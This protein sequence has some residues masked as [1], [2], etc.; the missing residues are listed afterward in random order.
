MAYIPQTKWNVETECEDGRSE[1]RKL[2]NVFTVERN[3]KGKK[4]R[5]FSEWDRKDG[6]TQNKQ[7]LSNNK[8][9][10]IIFDFT[11]RTPIKTKRQ[12]KKYYWTPNDFTQISA[13]WENWLWFWL[14]TLL[15]LF[16]SSSSYFVDDV[17]VDTRTR[18]MRTKCTQNRNRRATEHS[19]SRVY[20]FIFVMFYY[21]MFGKC[22][23]EKLANFSLSSIC[24][25]NL[26]SRKRR[27]YSLIFIRYTTHKF[28]QQNNISICEPV[29]I[30]CC[31]VSY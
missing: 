18:T 17:I 6:H 10:Y 2:R 24:T 28:T 12:P 23:V 16:S 1:A 31:T 14:E 4:R 7:Q 21:F 30:M 22:G 20:L 5:N 3:T 27:N 9:M 13:K 26:Q 29:R 15:I 8:K 11:D 19:E 25:L